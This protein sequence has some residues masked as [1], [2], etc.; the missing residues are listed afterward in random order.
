MSVCIISGSATWWGRGRRWRDGQRQRRAVW[1]MTVRG[2]HSG[3]ASHTDSFS[4]FVSL[5]LS[6]PQLLRRKTGKLEGQGGFL[7]ARAERCAL[8]T[9]IEIWNTFFHRNIDADCDWDPSGG[10]GEYL[11]GARETTGSWFYHV[12]AVCPW[13]S[14]LSCLSFG[15]LWH[16]VVRI[17]SPR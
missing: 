5:A 1:Q 15:F 9:V 12:C 7:A 16:G 17:K 2:L 11:A 8:G 3:P 13:A 4:L 10:Q 14:Y 6:L